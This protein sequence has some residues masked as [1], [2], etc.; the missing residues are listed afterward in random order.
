LS[1]Y[2]GSPIGYAIC[3]NGNSA[4]DNPASQTIAALYGSL[5]LNAA[6]NAVYFRVE[7]TT[8]LFINPSSCSPQI[9]NGLALGQYLSYWSSVNAYAFNNVSDRREKTDIKPSVLGLDF[10]NALKPVSYKWKVGQNNAEGD[11]VTPRP[12]VR[13][14]YGLIAQDVKETIDTLNIGD[15][16]GWILGDIKDPESSQGLNYI[17]F[18][19]P[20]V[21][22]IQELTQKNNA[23]ESLVQ[24]LLQRVTALERNN[25]N[26]V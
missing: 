15:F 19:S 10:I 4:G 20:M 17:Q 6:V 23:L 14:H 1:A 5:T 3:L 21:K 24:D 8:R 2:G 18:I 9:N 7:N 12:G 26:G 22:A 16:G 13:T 11:V 25:S